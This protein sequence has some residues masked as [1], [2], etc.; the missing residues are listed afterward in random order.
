[1]LFWRL[2]QKESFGGRSMCPHCRHILG[3]FDLIP[4]FSWIFLGGK[5]R[6][7]KKPISARYPLIELC[8]AAVFLLIG[9]FVF[10]KFGIKL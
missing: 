4:V 9:W 7:C 8:T 1:M 10:K 3:V 5:C 2:K 6:Y